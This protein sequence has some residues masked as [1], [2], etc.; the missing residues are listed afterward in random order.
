[1]T[2]VLNLVE[3][4]KSLFRRISSLKSN[5]K[6]TIFQVS[7]KEANVFSVLKFSSSGNYFKKNFF[8]LLSVLFFF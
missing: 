8:L 4:V 5:F 2:D 6:R 3:F 1:M 7:N